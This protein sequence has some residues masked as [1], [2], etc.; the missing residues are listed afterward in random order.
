MGSRRF[1]PGSAPLLGEVLVPGDKSLSH[2]AVLLS[3]MA[4]G[5]TELVGVL[6]SADVRSSIDAACA[7]GA[8]VEMER[9]PDG[10]L[11][12]S[13]CGWGVLGPQTPSAPIDCGNSGTTCRLLM[14]VLA[15]WPVDV[16]MVGDASLSKRPMRRVA[17]P[18]CEMGA[19]LTTSPEGT[20][21]VTMRR[22]EVL[23]PIDYLSPVSSAQVKSAVLLAGLRAAGQTSVTEPA[24]SRDH[25]ERLLPAFGIAV[26]VGAKP[27]KAGVHGPAILRSPGEVIVPRDPSSAAFLVAAALLV[28]G[29]R[30]RLPGVSL[31]E[32]R[33]GFLRVVERMGANIDVVP[34]PEAGNER[35][36]EINVRYTRD[37]TATTISAAE[38]PSL[39]DEVPIL[40]L[41][42]A[43]AEGETRFEDA[44]ELRVK[45]SDRF[46]AVV[47]GLTALGA[48]AFAD[49]DALV[50]RG[51]RPLVGGALDS[52]GDHRLAMTW[53]IAGLVAREVVIVERYEAVDVSYPEFAR[54]LAALQ[55]HG[56]APLA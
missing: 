50:I 40:A 29:S 49:G 5:T 24:L 41:V 20:L 19:S 43:F 37:L 13:V 9:Q 17:D 16:T 55:A 42:A 46:A 54:D 44:S 10:S 33:T 4:E 26:D 51:G 38:L 52:L 31:N 32:T 48:D 23:Q 30:V 12:G 2:R 35:V 21:P 22:G 3:A 56:S 15:G 11:A 1:G 14:G 27:A 53:A 7:L 36:G 34:F 6:D 47:D 8:H 39:V 25:T 18:L 28:P 45:E